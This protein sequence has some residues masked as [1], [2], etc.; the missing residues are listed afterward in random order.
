ML[1][2]IDVFL[3]FMSSYFGFV[4][5]YPK[6]VI[7][8]LKNSFLFRVACYYLLVLLTVSSFLMTPWVWEKNT[9][10]N[11]LDVFYTTTSAITTT[12]L[13]VYDVSQ[14]MTFFGQLLI[15]ILIFAGGFGLIFF[16]VKLFQAIRYL[17]T[18]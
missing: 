15:F 3:I 10:V 9:S 18:R 8:N 13:T 1:A 5:S 12:G 6:K 4:T 11:F 16:K 2:Y 7:I 17:F 14:E